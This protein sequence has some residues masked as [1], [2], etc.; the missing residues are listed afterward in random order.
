MMTPNPIYLHI[1][2]MLKEFRD[3]ERR[4]S[5]VDPD[6]PFDRGDDYIPFPEDDD[7][8]NADADTDGDVAPFPHEESLDAALKMARYVMSDKNG[9]TPDQVIAS[10]TVSEAKLERAYDYE[11]QI[12][13]LLYWC[14]AFT[15]THPEGKV[16]DTLFNLL[17][18]MDAVYKTE[19]ECTMEK[20][21]GDFL[22]LMQNALHAGQAIMALK[23]GEV[24][25]LKG[26]EAS[27]S[28]TGLPVIDGYQEVDVPELPFDRK[29]SSRDSHMIGAIPVSYRTSEEWSRLR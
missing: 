22:D 15:I 20:Q 4:D 29:R 5:A 6:N 3:N 7:N 27:K 16:A 11:R 23:R 14:K 2:Q 8:N 10:I 9:I 18:S 25:T 28:F 19:E 1:M 26:W 21:R 12:L 17:A 13:Q 24:V